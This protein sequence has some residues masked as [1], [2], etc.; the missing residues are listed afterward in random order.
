M[1]AN[2]VRGIWVSHVWLDTGDSAVVKLVR[3][4]IGPDRLSILTPESVH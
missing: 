3:I 1:D 4:G 2:N